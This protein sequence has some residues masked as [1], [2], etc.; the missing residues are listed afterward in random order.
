MPVSQA[1]GLQTDLR[2]VAVIIH[3]SIEY[4]FNG[5]IGLQPTFV[6]HPEAAAAMAQ[7]WMLNQKQE[8]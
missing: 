4:C 1:G 3:W 8:Y 7:R 6:N 2:F 5:M